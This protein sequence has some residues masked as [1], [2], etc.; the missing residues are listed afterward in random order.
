[1]STVHPPSSKKPVEP[2]FAGR[3]GLLRSVEELVDRGGPR[4]V[5]LDGPAGIG[6]SR[7]LQ[8]LARRLTERGAVVLA[9]SAT[10]FEQVLPFGAFVD[11]IESVGRTGAGLTFGAGDHRRLS[12]L[13]Q[14]P[15]YRSIREAIDRHDAPHGVLLVLDDV[16]WADEASLGLLEFLLHRPPRNLTAVI[17]SYRTGTCPPRLTRALHALD[18]PA[19]HVRV[20]PLAQADVDDMFPGLP[21]ASRRLL[22]EAG[23][24]NPLYLRLLAE[25]PVR[26]LG[27]LGS[28][29]PMLDEAVDNLL[30]ETIRAELAGLAAEQNLVVRAVAVGGA[31]V[32]ADL[33]AAVAQLPEDRVLDILDAL[34]GRGLLAARSG[35]FRFTHPLLRA[36][37]YGLSGPGWR[38]RAHRRAAEHLALL[39]APLVLQAQHLQHS[40]RPGDTEARARLA[41]AASSALASAPAASAQW[42]AR[43]L[44]ALPDTPGTER[45]R[46]QTQLLLARAL[47]ASGQLA[48]ADEVLEALRGRLGADHG[49]TVILLAQCTRMRGRARH[50]YAMLEDSAA[51]SQGSDSGLIVIEL[52]LIDLMAGRIESGVSR[53]RA[54]SRARSVSD[55]ESGDGGRDDGGSGDR[56]NGAGGH[57]RAV[58]AG[59]AALLALAHVGGGEIEE[60][61]RGLDAADRA[62]DALTDDEFKTILE[63]AIPPMAWAAYLLE[64]NDRALE[65]LER[66]IR[67][68]R[69]H[70]HI[71]AL[72]HLYTV[73]AFVLTRLA[74]L[75]EAL[76]AAQDAEET[77]KAFG[78]TDMV[79]MA[80][81]IGLRCQLWMQGPEAVRGSWEEA[82]SLPPLDSAW[83]RLSVS[84]T[85]VEVAV[86]SGFALS[87]DPAREFELGQTRQFDPTQATRWAYAAQV[88]LAHEDADQART[89]AERGVATAERMGLDCQLGLACLALAEVELDRRNA[90]AAA[91][92]ARRAID[93]FEH[94]GIEL[95]QGRA[96]LLAAEA[97]AL[98]DDVDEAGTQA[99]A[100]RTLFARVGAHWLERNAVRAQRRVAARRPH[101]RGGG[102]VLSQRERQVAELVAQGL[103]NQ[104]ISGRL[105]LSTRTVETHVSRVL[106][107]LGITSRSGVARRL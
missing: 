61:S 12:G 31:E 26:S 50:A 63:P 18:E 83:L 24:G 40:L 72:P 8:E 34:I 3:A 93:A 60:G 28:A 29:E 36:A 55:G 91:R 104:E 2:T 33:V 85:M 66:A 73:Q 10:E 39:D 92:A 106:A 13:E 27:A 99:A 79:P 94:A 1:L 59:C 49:E 37:A 75:P 16:Q 88:A 107:K 65:L 42:F 67:V 69:A 5:L 46:S 82:A 62:V 105:Y 52:A 35:R 43:V 30:G 15:F 87:A 19:T 22:T 100:A 71:Y 98:V 103:T 23:A 56:R 48:E 89:W 81:A 7:L 74:R 25:L 21:P 101:R 77:A 57:D 6:K 38:I 20:P 97:C 70:G 51:R 41:R 95:Q 11:V 45:Q 84:T 53:V 86:Q 54:L 47:L 76:A 90:K 96:H 78:V 14:I 68:A 102:P 4:V 58:A 80:R 17:T 44:E 9:G 32:G 64:R